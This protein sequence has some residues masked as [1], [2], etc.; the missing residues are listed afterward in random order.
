[1][2]RSKR[3]SPKQ[4]PPRPSPGVK[5]KV[6]VQSKSAKKTRSPQELSQPQAN[7]QS[8]EEARPRVNVWV[9]PQH[10]IT[11]P[12]E[13]V[14]ET[15]DDDSQN[16]HKGVRLMVSP[17]EKPSRYGWVR[18]GL[19]LL[20]WSG[21]TVG[22]VAGTWT[23]LQL[24]INPGSVTWLAWLFP[25]WSREAELYAQDAPKTLAELRAIA[26]D[27]GLRLGDPIPLMPDHTGNAPTDL[28]IP[29]YDGETLAELRVY[30]PDTEGWELRYRLGDRLLTPGPDEFFV[31]APLARV[32]AR[33]PGSSRA[34]P[35]N[36]VEA[37]SPQPPGRGLW[38]LLSGTYQSGRDRLQYGYIAHYEPSRQQVRS[39]MPWTSPNGK[40]PTWEFVTNSA[41]PELVIDQT[42]GLEPNFQI[43]Q[44]QFPDSPVELA[45]LVPISLQ[46]NHLDHGT[47]DNALLLARQGLWAP[48]Q[49]FL[50]SLRAQLGDRWPR[51]AQAQLEVIARHAAVT[52]QQAEQDWGTPG[53][54]VVALAIDGRWERAWQALMQALER[55]RSVLQM[56]RGND[57][58]LWRR[59]EAAARVSP[60]REAVQY[61]AVLRQYVRQ[62][63]PEAVAWLQR[64]TNAQGDTLDARSLR[65]LQTVDAIALTHGGNLVRSPGWMYGLATPLETVD[66]NAWETADGNPPDLP[67]D[68][69][70]YR[71]QVEQAH[72]GE[73]WQASPFP[74]LLNGAT[75]PR[76]LW[77]QLGLG[78]SAALRLT[79][80]DGARQPQTI[81]AIAH[82]LRWQNDRLEILVATPNAAGSA[83]MWVAQ[84]PATLSWQA[85][86]GTIRLNA[87]AAEDPDRATRLA[88]TLSAELRRIGR[89]P[90]NWQAT[91]QA[92]FYDLGSLTVQTLDLTGNDQ[93]D[94]I[95]EVQS[96]PPVPETPPDP[97]AEP[98]EDA[99]IPVRNATTRPTPRT[100]AAIFSDQGTL[101]YSDLG[102]GSG[103]EIVAIARPQGNAPPLLILRNGTQYQ[104]RRWSPE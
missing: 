11:P 71:V 103:T 74:G 15:A 41:T 9:S 100:Q 82:A 80:W 46:Q 65:I 37:F 38:L 35:L 22:M 14:D 72:D 2:R 76:F 81:E 10:R 6:V 101:L 26:Q 79:T 70:W 49:E 73:G 90:A 33:G 18:Q 34:L 36:R 12:E 78:R 89:L 54:A 104:L 44:L 19:T 1:M 75:T 58:R 48:A 56:L 60:R 86:R 42:V 59:V 87:L 31:T 53:Q 64:H 92:P 93:P 40:R 96:A 30:F 98:D 7:A 13:Q 16:A 99:A 52:R 51:G 20:L 66:A 68:Q 4:P 63:R 85:S 3:R 55:D 8:A 47:Y 5:V 57:N 83:S 45:E 29:V 77:S 27:K 95:L 28:L 21:L 25:E 32:T 97:L 88:A 62:G 84:T 17:S 94:F 69:Q 102:G 24:V 39:I 50:E 43:Y 91:G 23:A 61:W 67:P